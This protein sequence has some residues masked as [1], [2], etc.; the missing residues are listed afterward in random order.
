MQGGLVSH[1]CKGEFS[2]SKVISIENNADKGKRDR[3][4]QVPSY[5]V[6]NCAAH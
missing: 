3:F 6:Q 5:A 2:S 4:K 1:Y